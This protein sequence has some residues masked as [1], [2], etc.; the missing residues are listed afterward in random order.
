MFYLRN[1]NLVLVGKPSPWNPKNLDSLKFNNIKHI[2]MGKRRICI[3]DRDKPWNIQITYKMSDAM[4]Y[5]RSIFLK[6]SNY[7]EY[8]VF[9]YK[10][11]NDAKNDY[12]D[13]IKRIN[14]YTQGREENNK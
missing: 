12:I 5:E 3:T 4:L 13:I 1:I 6:K 9:R 7:Y 14:R 2:I 8:A 10:Y 11:E